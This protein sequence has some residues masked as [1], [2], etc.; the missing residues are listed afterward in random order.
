MKTAEHVKWEWQTQIEEELYEIRRY[1]HE[2]PE[3]SFQEFGTQNYI[4]SRLERWGIPYRK[5]TGTGVVVDIQGE[6]GTGKN[7]ALRADIDAL[8]IEEKSGVPFSSKNHGVMH[9]CGHDGHTTILL[10]AVYHLWKY[11]SE[12]SGLVR[13]IFQPGEEADGA[14]EKMINDGVLDNPQ[15]ESVVALHLWPK[16]PLGSIGVKTDAVTASCDDFEIEVIGEGGHAAR[17]HEATDAIAI[18]VDIIHSLKYLATKRTNPVEP[19]L[20]HVGTFHGGDAANVVADKATISGTIRCISPET[21]K[22]IK[23][24]FHHLVTGIAE[25]Y[26]GKVNI[27]FIDGH[28]P[29]I[30]DE[31]VTGRLVNAAILHIGRENIL[32]LTHPSMGADDFGFFSE[33]VPTAY[34][35]LGIQEEGKPIYDLHH[36]KFYFSEKVIPIGAK[37]VTQYALDSLNI[38]CQ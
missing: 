38:Q 24:D 33:R 5:V 12:F 16:L 37:I 19:V 3:L 22:K 9:A 6:E 25:Q 14:A 30:N 10:G 4:C 8:P 36:P 1:L 21:R 15:I 27:R 2:N 13:C 7:I 23:R 32:T 28:P 34:F 31:A 26:G 11:K 20:I 18:A 17:P 35:R 29:V